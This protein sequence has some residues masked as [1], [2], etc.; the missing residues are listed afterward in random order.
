MNYSTAVFLINNKV[1]AV[2]CTYE[3]EANAPKTLFKTFDET[4]KVDD[5][6]IVPTNTR[7]KMTICKVV[8]V[9]VDVDFDSSTQVEWVVGTVERANYEEMLAQEAA[10]IQ[11]IKAAELRKK[12]EDLRDSM[13]KNHMAEIAALPIADMT[14]A[15]PAQPPLTPGS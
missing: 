11:A 14:T 3:A 1:R 13:L 15:P 12:R 8:E 4:I 7:H 10:A 2:K 9:D 6:V 5:F